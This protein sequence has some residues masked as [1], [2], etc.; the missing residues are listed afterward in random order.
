MA[1]LGG[2]YALLRKP[3]LENADFDRNFERGIKNILICMGGADLTN[4]TL[5]IVQ[6]L[7]LTKLNL[8][9]NVVI[10]V[11]NR[12]YDE[13]SQWTANNKD[14]KLKVNLLSN[15]SADEMCEQFMQNDFLFTPAS[16]TSLEACCIGIPM[17]V[18]VIADNQL[19]IAGILEEKRVALNVRWYKDNSVDEIK[20]KYLKLIYDKKGLKAFSDLQKIIVDGKSEKR[21]RKL[22]SNLCSVR[23][24]V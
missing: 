1:Y 7:S 9:V 23:K 5:R 24:K 16:T 18:G 6:A 17:I 10:G 22:F 20:T 12:N 14:S 8:V 2:K 15:L 3:F 21:Y 4:Q 13:I 19:G 11:A